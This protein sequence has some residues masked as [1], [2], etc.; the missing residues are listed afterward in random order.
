MAQWLVTGRLCMLKDFMEH[1][2]S[3]GDAE[4]VV[5]LPYI[6]S[7]LFSIAVL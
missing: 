1:L 6:L 4:V 7:I 5:I 2:I 3:Q